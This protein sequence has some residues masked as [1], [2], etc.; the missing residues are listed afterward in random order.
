MP[1]F[2]MLL[3]LIWPYHNMKYAMNVLINKK[4]IVKSKNI[5]QQEVFGI[6]ESIHHHFTY[7]K[8]I[9][10]NAELLYKPLFRGK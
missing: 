6:V 4:I 7:N 3:G 8:A 10:N 9:D 5:K 1:E 2:G